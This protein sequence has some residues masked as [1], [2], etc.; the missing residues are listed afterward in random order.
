MYKNVFIKYIFPSVMSSSTPE[1]ITMVPQDPP[2][3]PEVAAPEVDLTTI[4]IA[5]T[6]TALN[7]MA[8]FLNLAQSRGVFSIPESA[9]IWECIQVFIAQSANHSP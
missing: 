3:A 8:A 2:P 5:D 9:K 1:N 4:P 7:V 6:L